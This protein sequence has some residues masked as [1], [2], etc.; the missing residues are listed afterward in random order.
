MTPQAA[1]TVRVQDYLYRN[2]PLSRAMAVSVRAA[3][4]ERVVLAAPLAPNIN[5]RETVFGGSAAALAILAAW[6]LLHLRLERE[7]FNGRIVIQASTIR[8]DK[9]IVD[10]F[11]AV[12]AFTDAPR[13]ARFTATLYRR[14][15]ARITLDAT[16]YCGG[17][18]VGAFSGEYVALWA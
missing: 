14:R 12:C 17:D 13:W 18:T 1:A 6:T 15:R 8:Y 7:T 16:L 5:H 2:I 10:A 11:E 4:T 9:P 3:H